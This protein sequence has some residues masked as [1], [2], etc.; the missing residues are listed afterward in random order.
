MENKKLTEFIQVRV[1]RELKNSLDAEASKLGLRTQD[2]VRMAIAVMLRG[3]NFLEIFEQ[4]KN[5]D[6]N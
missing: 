5:K 6:A 2:I 4:Y 1:S 3:R